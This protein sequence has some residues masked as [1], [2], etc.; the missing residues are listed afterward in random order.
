MKSIVVKSIVPKIV[1]SVIV[2]GLAVV[3]WEIVP[4]YASALRFRMALSEAC[5]T[6]ATGRHGPEEVRNDV[7]SKARLLD[8]PVRPHHIEV[9]VQPQLVSA[10][11]AYQVP[12]EL[13]PR[14]FVL[15]FRAAAQERPLVH[16]EDGEAYFQMIRE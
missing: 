10:I 6:A 12:V 15:N 2:L 11:V 13:G 16:M 5:R 8:L 7:L 4:V 1:R 14:E 3:V 9:Q